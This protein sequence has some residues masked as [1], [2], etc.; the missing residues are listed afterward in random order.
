MK[1]IIQFLDSRKEY[2]LMIVRIIAGWR[3][4]SGTWPFVI[5][6][7]SITGVVDFFAQVGIP[8]PSISAYLAVYAQFVCALLF[9]IGFWVRPAAI[10]MIFYFIVAIMVVHLNDPISK[11][12]QAWSL[13]AFSVL[14]L[15]SGAGRIA[16]DSVHRKNN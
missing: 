1:K 4:L 14:L 5:Q 10:V 7:K 6:T 2:S 11:S 8:I 3:L 12:F 9:I 15:F 16:L 13:L